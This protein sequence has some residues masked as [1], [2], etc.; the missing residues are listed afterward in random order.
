[1]RQKDTGKIKTFWWGRLCFIWGYTWLTIKRD[2][3][4]QG[5]LKHFDVVDFVLSVDTHRD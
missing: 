5:K 3:K 4:I 2:K 1:M